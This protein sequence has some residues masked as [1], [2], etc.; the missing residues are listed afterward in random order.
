MYLADIIKQEFREW[1]P[2]SKVFIQ[3][4]TGIGKTTFVMQY[5]LP[6]ALEEGREILYVS[7]RTILQQQLVAEICKIFKISYELIEKKGIMEFKGITFVSYQTLQEKLKENNNQYPFYDYII[8]DEAHYLVEDANFNPAILRLIKWIPYMNCNIF[9]AIS[10]TM[11][12]VLPYLGRYEKSWKLISEKENLKIF[13]RPSQNLIC[14]LKGMQ[15]CMYHYHISQRKSKYQIVVYSDIEDIVDMINI[16]T[17]EKKWLIFQSSKAGANTKIKKQ[18]QCLVAFI[19][20]EEKDGVLMQ[21]LIEEQQFKEKV[22]IATKVIDNGVSLHDKKLVNLVMDTTSKTEF[23]QMIGR[24]RNVD[25]DTKITLYLPKLSKSYFCWILY[26]QIIPAQQLLNLPQNEIKEKL[27]ISEDNWRIIRR[28]CL[29]E[30]GELRINQIGKDNLENQKQYIE[31]VISLLEEDELAF[32]KEQLSWIGYS[33]LPDDIIF[34]DD[35]KKKKGEQEICLYLE[36]MVGKIISHEEQGQLREALQKYFSKI[37]PKHFV[38]KN[39]KMGK[40]LINQCLREMHS[41][42]ELI[43]MPGK[44]KG[45]KSKWIIQH[46]QK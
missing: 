30:K 22:L 45:E 3:A 21:K 36:Q 12:D 2:F 8:F 37:Y 9:I 33:D 32:V 28:F 29:F 1:Q 42:F 46:C 39:R 41:D 7:N 24:R 19:S 6:F 20:A 17:T 18:L 25:D 4:P 31:K 10:A 44:K 27:L 13:C 5:L 43:S 16:D 14:S 15:E 23:L 40:N 26:K 35:E 11:G 34:L 38:H